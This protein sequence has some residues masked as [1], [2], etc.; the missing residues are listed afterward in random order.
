MQFQNRILISLFC[1]LASVGPTFQIGQPSAIRCRRR[2]PVLSQERSQCF[3][4]ARAMVEHIARVK[5]KSNRTISEPRG[6][7]GS[8]AAP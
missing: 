1:Y 5:E 6:L 7:K 2:K 8:R 3:T 4:S